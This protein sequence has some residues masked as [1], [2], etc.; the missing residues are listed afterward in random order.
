MKN[1]YLILFTICFFT[2]HLSAQKAKSAKAKTVEKNTKTTT[3]TKEEVVEEPRAAAPSKSNSD[4]SFAV[5]N[6][7]AELQ[8]VENTKSKISQALIEMQPGVIRLEV[9]S[10][11]IKDGKSSNVSYEFNMADIDEN[12]IRTYTNKD[13]IEVQLLVGKKQ[14]LIK[15]TQDSKKVSYDNEIVLF[16]KDIDNGRKLVDLFK[17]LVPIST[18]IIEKRLSLKTYQD[19]INWLET[20]I[21]VVNLV[22]K[23]YIQKINANT[24]YPGRM[25]M[26]TIEVANQKSNDSKYYFNLSN[27][28]VHSIYS[29]IKG[30]LI[31]VNVETKRKLKTVKVF[32]ST[33]QKNYENGFSIYCESVEKSR[34]LQKVLKA[35]ITLADDKIESTIPKISSVSQGISIIDNYIKN[36]TINETTFNQSF[37]GDCVVSF[38]K[39]ESTGAKVNDQLYL[40]NLK[41]L[42]INLTKYNT[43]GKNVIVELQTKGGDRFVKLT[44]NQEVKN[45]V[46]KFEIEFSEVED[47]VISEK[48]LQQMIE[49]CEKTELKLVGSKSDLLNRLKNNIKKVDIN[50]LTYEQTFDKKDETSIQ[51]VSTEISDKK[52]KAKTYEFNL[53]DINPKTVEINT[54][55]TNVFVTV[56]T[57]YLEKIIKYY[58]DGVISNY[59]NTF[60]I[61]TSN[62]EEAREIAELFKKIL[63]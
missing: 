32:S 5:Q 14:K 61:Y 20:N 52:S 28:N 63:D 34:D 53:K 18:D 1:K 29:E 46:N 2:F 36:I 22:D 12:T 43:S 25:E 45:Y 30:D 19:H 39:K 26:T 35:A 17:A 31:I 50:N 33:E 27:L 10:T 24:K 55:K 42:G 11:T 40:F 3:E 6:V 8:T 13:V 38:I 62:I 47:A 56:K 49:L 9:T 54:S 21:T 57:N 44:E 4:F 51:F 48:V 37:S 7:N 41:D 23:Q 60:N 15:N 59:Q 16:A 58:E